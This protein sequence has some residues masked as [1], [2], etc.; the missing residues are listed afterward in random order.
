MTYFGHNIRS[1]EEP[2]NPISMSTILEVFTRDKFVC[3]F[4]KE[5]PLYKPLTIFIKRKAKLRGCTIE[6]FITGCPQCI[7]DFENQQQVKDITAIPESLLGK[8]S[9]RREQEVL[10]WEWQRKNIGQS[11]YLCEELLDHWAKLTKVPK[12][13]RDEYD[14]IYNWMG[15]FSYTTILEAMNIAYQQYL[16]KSITKEAIEEAFSKIGGIAHNR[17][18]PHPHLRDVNYIVA[19]LKNRGIVES[20]TE[21]TI[22]R[23][24]INENFDADVSSDTLRQISKQTKSYEDFVCSL[25]L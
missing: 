3:Q 23:E 18:N 1:E 14:T 11:G 7:K 15:Q 17:T 16:C 8:L 2:G 9:D 24:L 12:Y 10:M 5:P 20:E 13:T 21:I 4:C 25:Q 22:C 19:I 6:D